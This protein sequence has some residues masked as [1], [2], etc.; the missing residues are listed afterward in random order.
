[1][2]RKRRHHSGEFKAKVTLA[3]PKGDQTTPELAA[4]FGVHPTQVSQWK[5]ELQEKAS[6][7]FDGKG[8]KAA[9]KNQ[10]EIDALCQEIGKLTV[11]RVFYHESSIVEPGAAREGV[12]SQ[13]RRS[14]T[15][16][17]RLTL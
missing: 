11:E 8:G 16:Y 9:H 4:R 6:G 14:L 3:A 5:S 12:A 15:T 2:S 7:H 17:F 13:Q 10:E 1:M